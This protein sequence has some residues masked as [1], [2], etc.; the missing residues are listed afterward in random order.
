VNL[1][2]NGLQR[3]RFLP[4]I[5]LL[6]THTA[7]HHVQ[8]GM[9]FRLR[10]LEQA[11]IYH[12]PLDDT[13]QSSLTRSFHA[14]APENPQANVRL[15]IEGR[16]IPARFVADD[17]VWFDFADLCDGPRSQNDYIELAMLYHA[18][19]VSDVPIL[20]G[21]QENAARRFISLVDEFYDHGVKLIISAAA[22][23][24]ELYQGERLRF[25]FERTQSRLLEMQSHD[26]L[27]QSHQAGAVPGAVQSP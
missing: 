4:A 7:V 5:D 11:E 22:P 12:W 24:T 26:Y 23:I 27:A 18:V 17:V 20:T 6:Y 19:F 25:E 1:Y 16:Q 8:D 9:D 10:A 21:R 2:E 13:A 3:R 14:L 15:E